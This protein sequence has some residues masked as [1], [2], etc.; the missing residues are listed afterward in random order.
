MAEGVF[1]M[2]EINVSIATTGIT[3]NESMD[4]IP[5]GT[6]CTAWG[7]KKGKH[8]KLFSDTQLLKGNRKEICHKAVHHALAKLQTYH[9]HFLN[10]IKDPG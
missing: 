1:Q 8:M 4:G 2:K 5:P 6:I 3:G 10:E 9:Q 7:F